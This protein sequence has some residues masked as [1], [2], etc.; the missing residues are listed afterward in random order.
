MLLNAYDTTV[1]KPFAVLDKVQGV[2][3]TLALMNDFTPSEKK[4][5]YYIDYEN[6]GSL[7]MFIFPLSLTTHDRSPITVLDRR[8]Y[9]NKKDV[10][11]NYPEYTF[12]LVTACLQQDFFEGNDTV[13]QS[14]RYI[15]TRGFARSL[16]NLIGKSVGMDAREILELTIILA[17]YYTCLMEKPAQDYQFVSQNVI[18]QSLGYDKNET[19]PIIE[20]MGYINNIPDL[21]K[22]LNNRPGFFKLK[23]LSEKSFIS[24]GSMV[25]T[26]S[27]GGKVIGAA[28][29]HPPLFTGLCYM[30]LTNRFYLKTRLGGQLDPK[31]NERGIASFL[32]TISD[33]YPIQN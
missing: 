15:P 29:E 18:K 14:T 3:K 4:G 25:S 23:T 6:G 12:A 31:Y 26:S 30:T 27:M 22:Y 24:F 16:G 19:Q 5:V 9:N 1:G 2:L 21:V 32:R 17:H 28:L 8:P 10:M 33:S 20:D 7:P 11:V 13:L